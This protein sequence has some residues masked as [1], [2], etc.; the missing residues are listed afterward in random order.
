MRGGTAGGLPIRLGA[1]AVGRVRVKVWESG[2][3]ADVDT[4]TMAADSAS[5]GTPR[6]ARQE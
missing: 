5:G 3:G 2:K 4:F 6:Q 1:N